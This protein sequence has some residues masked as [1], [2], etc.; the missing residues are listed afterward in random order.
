MT[1]LREEQLRGVICRF[2]RFSFS[3]DGA[4]RMQT[5][6]AAAADYPTKALNFQPILAL[7]MEFLADK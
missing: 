4:S 1:S 7:L 3:R 6:A 2:D 5:G